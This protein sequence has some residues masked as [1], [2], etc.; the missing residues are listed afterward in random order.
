MDIISIFEDL[1]KIPS[2]SL[3]EEE[4]A[5]KI[6]EYTYN[7][8][9]NAYFDDYKNVIIK[10]PANCENKKPLLLSARMDV[11]GNSSPVDIC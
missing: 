10:I 11:V 2:P 3:N 1:V 7:N 6:M 5:K 9:I 8:G 4:V